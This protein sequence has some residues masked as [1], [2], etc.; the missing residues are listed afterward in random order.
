MK[1]LGWMHRKFR[2]T[3]GEPLKDLVIGNPCNCL[4]GQRSIDDQEYYQHTN[5]GVKPARHGQQENRLRKSFASLEVARAEYENRQQEEF[6]VGEPQLFPGFLAIGTLGSDTPL[7]D[8]S[9]PTFDNSVDYITEKETEMTENELRLINDELEKVLVAEAKEDSS[10]D[11]SGRSSQVS[12][13]RSSHGS[14]ITLSG[15][16][17]LEGQETNNG[18]TNTVYPLQGYLFGSAIELSETTAAVKKEHRTSLGELF[19]RSKL[20]EDVHEL[21]PEREERHT[22]MNL[23][24]KK[25]KKKMLLP[26]RSSTATVGMNVDSTSAETKLQKILQ[27]FHRKVHPESS[28]STKKTEK[29]QQK[30]SKKKTNQES[31]KKNRDQE[32]HNKPPQFKLAGSESNGNRECWIKT[33]ADYLVLEL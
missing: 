4:S 11:S 3:G 5:Y 10:N 31:K 13:G 28:A 15:K 21:K 22:A 8:P 20:T 19:Q 16:P 1:L 6:L 26:S 18:S 17:I 25:L 23:M 27:M 7:S 32:L 33:D 14:T 12:M 2:Q 9:T 30:E 24:K 29:K